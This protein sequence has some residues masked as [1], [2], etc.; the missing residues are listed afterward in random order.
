MN[1]FEQFG[2][3]GPEV[4]PFDEIPKSRKPVSGFDTPLQ[5]SMN[6]G[7]VSCTDAE[8]RRADARAILAGFLAREA[9]KRRDAKTRRTAA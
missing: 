8:A 7:A 2:E 1:T 3:A 9:M 6:V 4:D 5:Y